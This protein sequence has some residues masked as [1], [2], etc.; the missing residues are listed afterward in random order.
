MEVTLTAV[1]NAMGRQRT[2]TESSSFS[3]Y[4]VPTV[5]QAGCHFHRL[6]EELLVRIFSFLH[7]VND[8]LPLYAGVCRK[9]RKVLLEASTVWRELNIEPEDYRPKHYAT[10]CT[11][12]TVYG[13]HVQKLTWMPGTRVYESVFL[14][15]PNLTSLTVLRLP[16]IWNRGVVDTFSP[17]TRLEELQINGAFELHDEDL[18]SAA[19]NFP[20]LRDV[21]LNAC[22]L[23]TY[24]GIEVFL[25]ALPNLTRCKLKINAGLPI[26]DIRSE[27]AM[28]RGNQL[29]RHLEEG[30]RG[31]AIT[32]LSLSFLA[33][34]MDELWAVVNA[35]PRLKKLVV[36][37]CER[38]HGVRIHSSSLQKI[39]FFNLWS[40]LFVS[41]TAPSLRMLH[42]DDGLESN[43]HVEIFAGKLRVLEIDGA[44]VLKSINVQSNRLTTLQLRNCDVLD[45][46]SLYNL[47]SENPTISTLLMGNVSTPELLLDS[48]RCP[49]V[50]IVCLLHGFSSDVLSIRCP[51]LQYLQTEDEMELLSLR[52][53]IVAA[54]QV[55]D[56]CLTG[57]PVLHNILVQCESLDELEFNMCS[58]ERVF[59]R[60]CVIQASRFVGK[61]RLFDCAIATIVLSSPCISILILY[62][63]MIGDYT[64]KCMLNACPNITHL[65]LEKCRNTKVVSVPKDA[66]LLRYLNLFGCSQLQHL[67]INSDCVMR[68][69]LGQCSVSRVLYQ[70][71]EL[72]FA[73]EKVAFENSSLDVVLPHQN[74]RWSHDAEPLAFVESL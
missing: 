63:C 50:R 23:I 18:I 30:V 64:L 27:Q 74:V 59:L 56:I 32:S 73:E 20:A 54:D 21:T 11:I 47:L 52:Q 10:L 53:L 15:I 36:A 25:E 69:N 29:T 61:I 39:V 24:K 3:D 31:A 14:L 55:K 58:D 19:C 71:K 5:E 44:G 70:G 66:P 49:S 62:R 57:C 37:N 22:W 45:S 35:L 9:W 40:A 16:I 33:L 1:K 46:R 2:R 17:L 42:L 68:V 48:Q 4:E 8:G 41:I 7:P 72:D 28:L 34:E 26:S 13:S 43:E 12:F 67:S 51:T 65:S 60:S 6:P 38:L